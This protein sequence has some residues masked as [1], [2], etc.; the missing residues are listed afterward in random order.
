MPG[1]SPGLLRLWHWLNH[2]ARSYPPMEKSPANQRNSM[3]EKYIF[4]NWDVQGINL[5]RWNG[6]KQDPNRKRI[7]IFLFY[8]S[9]SDDQLTHSFY[10]RKQK[11]RQKNKQTQDTHVNIGL[12]SVW[13]GWTWNSDE[14]PSTFE[15]L[16]FE[17]FFTEVTSLSV[18]LFVGKHWL[19]YC[20]L[21]RKALKLK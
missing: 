2:S 16:W 9:N 10:G 11:I 14:C 4:W 3:I 7:Y 19:L 5:Q 20:I 1:L 15:F 21:N 18:Q 6:K 12:R 17:K 13:R 8:L